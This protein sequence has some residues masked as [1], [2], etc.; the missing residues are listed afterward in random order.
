MGVCLCMHT[1]AEGV[2]KS[3]HMSRVHERTHI[4]LTERRGNLILLKCKAN[5][6]GRVRL[7]YFL[8]WDLS[9]TPRPSLAARHR[10]HPATSGQLPAA[11]RVLAQ[12]PQGN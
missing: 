6:G 3:M 9:K 1:R 11:A 4:L 7:L 8:C 10:G 2:K 5:S 12:A